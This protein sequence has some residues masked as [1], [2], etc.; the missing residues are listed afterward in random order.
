MHYL[1]KCIKY[2]VKAKNFICYSFVWKSIK[3][4]YPKQYY[5]NSKSR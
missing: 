2:L 4:A 1:I 3:K 5:T